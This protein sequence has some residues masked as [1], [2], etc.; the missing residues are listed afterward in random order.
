MRERERMDGADTP[1]GG[2]T[3]PALGPMA[4]AISD[5]AAKNRQCH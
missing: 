4:L 2:T 3:A 1:L 5:A